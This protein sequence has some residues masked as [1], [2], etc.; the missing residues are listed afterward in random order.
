MRPDPSP[1]RSLGGRGTPGQTGFIS[2]EGQAAGEATSMQ[3]THTALLLPAG[4]IS[5][6]MIPGPTPHP[7]K[8]KGGI[9]KVTL[10]LKRQL[11]WNKGAM[12]Q[13]RQESCLFSYIQKV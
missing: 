5:N 6:S 9:I 13:Q 10:N 4:L 3:E 1:S 8:G 7:K 12:T 11:P 2:K